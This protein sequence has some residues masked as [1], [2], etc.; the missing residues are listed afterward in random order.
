MK[1]FLRYGILIPKSEFKF[2][3]C[4]RFNG[5]R[6]EFFY[7]SFCASTILEYVHYQLWLFRRLPS[8]SD[9]LKDDDSLE[10][11]LWESEQLP[12]YLNRASPTWHIQE[13]ILVEVEG[14]EQGC[15]DCESD[16]NS[17]V[18][19]YLHERYCYS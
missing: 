10:G 3:Y 16:E 5:S 7:F 6:P 12:E 1:M 18:P 19:E 14:C 17:L 2:T 15:D 13:F 4:L 11:F 8:Q 9:A